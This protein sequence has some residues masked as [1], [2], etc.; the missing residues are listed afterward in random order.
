MIEVCSGRERPAEG[1]D[2]PLTVRFCAP[3]AIPFKLTAALDTEL[4]NTGRLALTSPPMWDYRIHLYS[5][6]ID[7]S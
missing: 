2:V 6:S 4:E 3:L 1:A 5:I 7:L